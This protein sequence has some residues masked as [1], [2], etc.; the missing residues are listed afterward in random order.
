EQYF[1]F[2][3]EGYIDIPKD[4]E[5]TFYLATNDGGRLYLDNIM[6]LNNDGLHP[7][8]EIEKAVSLKA[9]LHPISV[10]YFQEGGRNGLIVSWKG[11]GI[12]KQEIPAS[13]LFHKKE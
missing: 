9:G 4:G 13:V 5:Y 1:S 12:E 6:L 7:V 3:Y 2:D 8:V 11:P 10:K